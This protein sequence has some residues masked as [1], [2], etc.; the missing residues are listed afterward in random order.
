MNV[1]L[2]RP[3][4]VDSFLA[5][6]DDQELRHEFDGFQTRAMTGGTAGHA[7]IQMNLAVALG[8]R[9][10]GKPRRAFGSDLK[11]RLSGSARYPDAQVV[12]SPVL[13][14][15]EWVTEP[16]VVFEILSPSTMHEDLVVKNAEYQ[17]TPSIQHYVVL[18]QAHAAALVF[19]RKGGEWVVATLSGADA[20]LVLPEIEIEIPLAELYADVGL[21]SDERA[22]T[23][24]AVEDRLP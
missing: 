2:R 21:A 4:T 5:W 18:E 14:T 6:E 3:M 11:I 1:A 13:P 19:S 7:T 10:R 22:N 23:L 8:T 20:V 24:P 16:V 12:C 9:L 17:A 15:A